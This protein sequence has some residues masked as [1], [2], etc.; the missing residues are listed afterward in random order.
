MSGA[1]ARAAVAAAVAT[2]LGSCALLPVFASADWL[3]PVTATVVVVLAGGLLLRWAGPRVWAAATDGRPVPGRVAALGVPLVPLTQLFLVG[4]LLIALYAPARLFGGMLPTWRGATAIAGVFADG[5]AELREQS[6]PAL[7]LNGLLALTV[8]L[9]GLVA[10]AVDLIA[11]AG[12]QAAIA[13]AGLLV[14]YCVPVSTIVGG[15]GLLPMAAPAA[16]LALLLWTD[17]RRRLFRRD[18]APGS[19]VGIGGGALAALRIGLLALVAGLVVGTAVPTLGE[20]R[21]ASGVA[22]GGA[23]D[24][25]G[26][27][28]TRLDPVAALKGQLSLPNPVDLL[29][30]RA[31]V[32]DPGYLRAIAL[33][34]YSPSKGWTIGNLDDS[35]TIAGNADLAPLPARETSRTVQATIRSLQHDDRYLPLLYSPETVAVRGAGA[36]DWRFDSATSTVFGRNATTAGRT[37]T[38]VA[39]EPR[40]SVALLQSSAPLAGGAAAVMRRY[41][42]LP[43]LDPGVT[44]LVSRV[45]A[46]A[47]TPYD[48]VRAIQE[49]FTDPAN[50]FVYSLATAPGT[51]S[52]NLVNFL[53]NKKGYCEQFAG[54]MAVLV[55]SAGLP[56]RVALG[57]T[58]GTTQSDGSRLI[59]SHDAHAWVEVYFDGLGWVPFDP[60][61]IGQGR[62]VALPWAPQGTSSDPAQ[63]PAAGAVT[64]APSQA[65]RSAVIDKGTPFVPVNLS[66]SQAAWVRPVLIVG[67]VLVVGAILLALPPWLRAR[68]R[69]SRFADGSAAAL[70]DELAA[71]ARDLGVG[72]PATRTPRQTARQLAEL[73]RAA[74]PED[75]ERRVRRPDQAAE[76]IDAVRRLALAEEAAS[77]ARPGSGGDGAASLRT[78][79]RTARRG[80][81]R[82]T[83]WAARLRAALWPASLMTDLAARWAARWADGMATLAA[84]VRTRLRPPERRSGR[85]A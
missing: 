46:G 32:P 27:V 58:P 51:S 59:T 55:R 28:G 48:K 45:T 70:W 23:A 68:R 44:Q 71:T 13:G 26:S 53:T 10:V 22:T 19:R 76:A 62:A 78:A 36:E 39:E 64:A 57:Y 74:D 12:R 35:E 11:V 56:A 38:V 9:V 52:D 17:Q 3:G 65:V 61:P 85:T 83:P 18:R 66:A 49:Y 50:G 67:G 15:I 73:I 47:S 82:A 14:L 16:G 24:G 5:S 84:R 7:P 4:W 30:V 33:D 81:V 79:L 75:G 63:N 42:V 80:L 60:T 54:A 31:S 77:Y 8:L 2:L 6:T 21:F 1:D 72:W 34:V 69:R 37:Y 25:A 40:P 43:P 20:G 29:R 41:T